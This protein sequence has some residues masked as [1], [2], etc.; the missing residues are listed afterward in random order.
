MGIIK[1]EIIKVSYKENKELKTADFRLITYQNPIDNKILEFLTNIEHYNAFTI[2][3]L[4]KN[5]WVIEVLFKQLKQNFE[6]KYFLSD[7]E[8][9]IKSQIWMALILNL[10]FTVIHK[11]TKEIESFSTLVQIATKNLGV[12]ISIIQFIEQPF[13]I[14]KELFFE[15]LRK[16]QFDKKQNTQFDKT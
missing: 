14:H 11:I 1:D 13:A 9:G 8:N 2:S 10:L 4:Y 6:L 5:R 15:K 3:L 16:V 12:N 7:N